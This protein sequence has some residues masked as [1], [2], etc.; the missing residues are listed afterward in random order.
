[1]VPAFAHYRSIETWLKADTPA[2]PDGERLR[3]KQERAHIDGT[4]ECM[5]CFCC[6][7]GCSSY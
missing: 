2:P 4:W 7:A 3:S 6:T 1:M 5:L